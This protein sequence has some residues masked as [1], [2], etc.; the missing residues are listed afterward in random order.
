MNNSEKP[1]LTIPRVSTSLSYFDIEL[2]IAKHYD[3]RQHII[4]P[5]CYINFGTSAD[6]E[7]DLIII[8]R[9]G[10]AEE[11]EIKMSKSDLKAD[12]KKKHGHVGERLQHLYYAM[13]VELYEQCKELI[14]E[15]AGVF[16][17][18]KYEDR[19]FA[20][21]VKS[22]PKKQCRKLTTDEQ[23]KIARLGVMRI[24]NLKQKYQRSPV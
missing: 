10:Y 14:P 3:T 18:T 13:P 7:C 22:A 8:K 9:S 15:Y 23:L 4:V 20:R 6:H 17:I 5:N 16:T 1:Q 12:F 24:W 2:A 11:I 21:C 19:G